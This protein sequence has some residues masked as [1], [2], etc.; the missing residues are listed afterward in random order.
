ML[1]L[2]SY[3]SDPEAYLANCES[4]GEVGIL[5]Y[6]RKVMESFGGDVVCKSDVKQGVR[7]THFVLSFPKVNK[8]DKTTDNK[9]NISAKQSEDKRG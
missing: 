2:F 5:Y 4:L 6:V 9:S 3:P 7:Y 8:N 1:D